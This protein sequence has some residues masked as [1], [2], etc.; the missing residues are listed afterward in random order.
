MRIALFTLGTRGDV[1]PFAVLG[2]ALQQRGHQVTLSTAKNFAPLAK[3]FG[4]AFEPVEADFQAF[5]ET[6]EGKRMMK[7]PFRA[8]KHLQIW[9]FPMII[10]ALTTFYRVAKQHDKV[11][12][13]VKTMGEYFADAF[14]E[15]MIHCNV[16]PA[17]EPTNAFVNPIFS[18]L[19][20]PSFLHKLS[21]KLS[22]LG[23]KMMATPINTFRKNAGLPKQV[24][25]QNFP[26]IYG[27][28][29]HFLPR[30]ADYSPHT[31]YTGFWMEKS[32]DELDAPL[33]A[34]L[35]DG[36]P[37][38]LITFGS[39]PF[40]T[41]FNLA[42]AI[43][44]ITASHKVKVLV[45]KGWGTHDEAVLQPNPM[46]MLIDGAPY[47]KLFPLVTAVIHHGG[48]GTTA[49]CLYAGKPYFSCP[50]MYPLGDQHFWGTVGYKKGIALKPIPLRK[51]TSQQLLN[52]VE[53]LLN[54]PALHTNAHV[55]MQQLKTEDGVANAIALIEQL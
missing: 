20:V 49:A 27:I 14:P 8:R 4:L 53:E 50:V 54:T 21:Y 29:S 30:P 5:L 25:K 28:S 16:V 35:A 43:N 15:K 22:A 32:K 9:V 10:D 6:E 46:V 40:E 13:H 19:P 24:P 17:M 18:A 31:Y 55:L 37:A 2:K 3:A 38:I 36:T 23:L 52:K 48:I 47:D 1:Q 34:F 26:S 42:Q 12:F 7:N 33:L 39:M 11:L 51:L 45:V 41:R 44:A